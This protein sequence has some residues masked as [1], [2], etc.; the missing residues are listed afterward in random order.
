MLLNI[1]KKLLKT[2]LP[3]KLQEDITGDLEEEYQQLRTKCKG[4]IE[5]ELWLITQTVLT[6]S[7]FVFTPNNLLII[8]V[9]F[10]SLTLFSLMAL[11]II[12][13]SAY[14]DPSV[15]SASF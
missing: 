2:C 5:P 9:T 13:L 6:C 14:D 10:I 1:C 8:L 15:F 12:W 7:R 4:K 3:N 11:G